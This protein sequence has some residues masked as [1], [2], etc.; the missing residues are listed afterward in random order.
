M[1]KLNFLLVALLIV[2]FAAFA[3][4]S[5]ESTTKDQGSD[6]V[7]NDQIGDYTLVIDSCRMAKDM[8][9]QPV[10]IVKYIFS[11]VNDDDA[12]SYNVAF[13][14]AVYQ[15][16]VGLNEAWL[17]DDSADYD[18]ENQ[19]KEI[20]KGAT[21][22]V[23]VA[24]ELN[25][26]TTDIEVEVT[27]LFSFD[28][29]TITKT[30]SLGESSGST[31]EGTE[32]SDEPPA[33]PTTEATGST[34]PAETSDRLGD[35]SLII[36]SCR[37]AKDY[38]GKP[39]VIVKYIFGNVSDDDSAA[40]SFA[41][42]ANAYQNGVGLNEAYFLSDN[43]DYSMDNMSKEIKKG[44]SIEVEV[45]YVL[46]DT[47]TDIEVEVSELFSFDDSTITKTFSIA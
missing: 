39:V 14:D 4:G 18:M 34:Q 11:N 22:E 9:G 31:G 36:D 8:E 28:D 7:A 2:A 27:Q 13:D 33:E 32:T 40:F 25:D 41:L 38:E 37:M 21:I 44:A 16:G 15:N 47:T 10:V 30:L 17:V 23:E 42:D 1:K 3:M 20:K 35:Y 46:N 12:V 45:A 24:Y 19:S 5:G 43:A 6:T 29:T 26:T